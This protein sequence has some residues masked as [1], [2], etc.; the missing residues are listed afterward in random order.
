M[1]T[2]KTRFIKGII[3]APDNVALD[4]IDG[5]LKVDN[6]G[7]IKATLKDGANPSAPREIATLDQAQTLTNKTL[8]SPVIDTS[9][10]GTALETDLSASASSS[11]LATASAIKTYVDSKV[12]S[13]DEASEIAV[14]PSIGGFTANVQATLQGHQDLIDDLVILSGVA[15]SAENLGTF[16]GVTIPD[17]ST[18]KAALQAIETAHEEVDQ[19]VSSL[20]T[21]SGVAENATNL[22]TFTGTTIPDSSTVKG[23]LQSVETSFE[24]HTGSSIQHGVTSALVGK[25]DNQTLTQKT[26]NADNNTISNLQVSNLKA[27]V[28]DI[29]L[30]SVSAS[31]DT[32]PSAKAVKS[33]ADSLIPAFISNEVS[34]TLVNDQTSAAS[35]T[36]LIFSPATYRSAKVEYAI[37]RQTDTALTGVAQVGQLRLVY[38]SQQATWLLS[39]D[40]SGQNSGIEFSVTSLGQLQYKSSNILGT[41]YLG[42]LKYSIKKTFAI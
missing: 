16:T 32:L 17:S 2:K 31:D 11:K 8:T 10:S 13:K 28:L 42:T 21:L 15:A 39:D 3:L 36:G 9:V 18:I 22:G 4:G 6:N 37:Y 19:D 1:S 14:S 25:D 5:E 12:A 24:S 23:A 40:Y 27:G 29:D 41:N 33:Y 38:N 20:I 7:K 34:F 26:I 30:T 35:I